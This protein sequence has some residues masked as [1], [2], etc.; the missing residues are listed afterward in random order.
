MPFLIEKSKNSFVN[1]DKLKKLFHLYGGDFNLIELD[2]KRVFLSSVFEKTNVSTFK[3]KF[4]TENGFYEII[5]GNNEIIVNSDL[6]QT[7]PVYLYKNFLSGEVKNFSSIEGFKFSFKDDEKVLKKKHPVDFSPYKGILNLSSYNFV[8]D[9]DYKKIKKHLIAYHDT[10]K[11]KKDDQV[12]DYLAFEL[13]KLSQLAGFERIEC[14]FL[15]SGIDSS[16]V[17]SF[18]NKKKISNV[19]SIKTTLGDELEGATLIA[20]S[21]NARLNVSKISSERILG[22][23][24]NAIIS[25]EIFDGLSA[26]ILAQTMSACQGIEEVSIGSGHGSDLLFSGMLRHEA[27][28]QAVDCKNTKDLIER[29]IWTGEFRPHAFWKMGKHIH[30]F[31]WNQDFII[32][33]LQIDPNLHFDGKNEKVILREA[34]VRLDI[35]KREMAFFKKKGLTDGTQAHILLSR[36]LGMSDH[37]NFD[38]KSKWAWNF[39][40]EYLRG[41]T[42]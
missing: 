41:L 22:S 27:Y 34:A 39:L 24:K 13:T 29:T 12:V 1:Q 10:L 14:S 33:S 35:L 8:I 31:Y 15:S 20:E 30:F 7:Y 2:D 42:I 36:E 19:Y 28:M 40:K 21:I 3:S 4:A 38:N 23:F 16:I 26:E 32:K 25:N 6:M 11:V 37:Y 17:S 18:I 5:V 9:Q